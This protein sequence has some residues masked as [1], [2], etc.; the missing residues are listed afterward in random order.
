MANTRTNEYPISDFVHWHEQGLLNLNPRFQ[1]RP[2]WKPGAKSYLIDSI[3]R[4][5]PIPLVIL[6]ELPTDL[7]TLKTQREV[8]DGQQRLRTVIAFAAP[9]QLPS[10]EDQFVLHKS[11]Y[12][13][14]AGMA[15]RD[16]PASARQSILDYRISVHVL[17]A[18]VSD[19]DVLEI[20]SR[21]NATG[22]SL[23]EQELRNAE[24]Y[25]F[26][27]TLAFQLA[28][29]HLEF[30][31]ASKIATDYDI[32][33]MREVE[34]TSEIIVLAMQGISEGGKATLDNA[35]EVFD[36]ALPHMAAIASRVRF[37]IAHIERTVDFNQ[38][39]RM[40]NRPLFYCLCAAA[41]KI[42]FG[43]PPNCRRKG[44]IKV[45]A[46]NT[47]LAR[48]RKLSDETAPEQIMKLTERRSSHKRERERITKYLAGV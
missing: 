28:T 8:V 26:F 37:I 5:L 22:T 32:A 44:S 7:Q 4:E 15:F 30:W 16:M 11:H 18:S 2:T 6:R 23:N 38:M 43:L 27:K 34:L 41:L 36:G 29:E 25:G 21:L 31:R 14:F 35:Y 40:R 19:K 17:A 1:R 12:K 39:P 42:G 3:L 46:W 45:S 10:P 20:F 24:F 33:R 13:Q 48:A 9:D 47:V